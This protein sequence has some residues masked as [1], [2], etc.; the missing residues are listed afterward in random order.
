MS[1]ALPLEAEHG[2]ALQRCR[3]NYAQQLQVTRRLDLG[4]GHGDPGRGRRAG[5]PVAVARGQIKR[6]AGAALPLTKLAADEP[7]HDGLLI[8]DCYNQIPTHA[9]L[10]P[11]SPQSVNRKLT[12]A[13]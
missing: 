9:D 13:A 11:A 2:S 8:E 7:L 5:E 1:C 6:A 10:I 12:D 3:I 4:R